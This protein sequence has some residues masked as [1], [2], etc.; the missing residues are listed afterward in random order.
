MKHLMFWNKWN[1]LC[2]LK[3]Y[4]VDLFYQNLT[5]LNSGMNHEISQCYKV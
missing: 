4:F 5:E 3:K 2:L 1:T